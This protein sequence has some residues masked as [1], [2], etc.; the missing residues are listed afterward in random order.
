MSEIEKQI[1]ELMTKESTRLGMLLGKALHR[2]ADHITFMK[3]KKEW[4]MIA[5]K[6]GTVVHRE[7]TPAGDLDSSES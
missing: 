2:G 1:K 3:T 4:T 7:L 6:E 5:S